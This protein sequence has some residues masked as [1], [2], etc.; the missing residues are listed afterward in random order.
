MD[1]NLRPGKDRHLN[2]LDLRQQ[3]WNLLT[4]G[5]RLFDSP[6][7]KH[8]GGGTSQSLI[9]RGSHGLGTSKVGF[10]Q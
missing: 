3:S 1:Y 2:R 10:I 4:V 5:G 7:I 6:A 9:D 8:V